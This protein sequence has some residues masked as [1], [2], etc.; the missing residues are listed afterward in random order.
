MFG[1]VPRPGYWKRS[2]LKVARPSG[3]VMRS[4]DAY[5]NRRPRHFSSSLTMLRGLH[6]SGHHGQGTLKITSGSYNCRRTGLRQCSEMCPDK[7]VPTGQS[8]FAERKVTTGTTKHKRTDSRQSRSSEP[9]RSI[10]AR[11]RTTG[12]RRKASSRLPAG[13]M[14]VGSGVGSSCDSHARPARSFG[15]RGRDWCCD[16]DAAPDLAA[17]PRPTPPSIHGQRASVRT[18]AAR[19]CTSPQDR[20]TRPTSRRHRATRKQRLPTLGPRA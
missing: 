5:S 13:T 6:P 10:R 17:V 12:R 8:A 4:P 15:S 7:T 9:L 1:N 19:R 16:C 14:C 2:I 20:H 18:R 3:I 11:L